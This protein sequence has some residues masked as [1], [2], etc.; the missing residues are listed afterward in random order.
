LADNS[1]RRPNELGKK[2]YEIIAAVIVCVLW[3]TRGA[4]HMHH[5]RPLGNMVFVHASSA[6]SFGFDLLKIPLNLKRSE[7]VITRRIAA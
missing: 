6:G 2:F 5:P 3:C 4:T 1:E 7:P